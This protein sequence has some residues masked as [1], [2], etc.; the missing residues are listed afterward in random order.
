MRKIIFYGF[1]AQTDLLCGSLTLIWFMT[2]R[3]EPDSDGLH[4]NKF[5]NSHHRI[6]MTEGPSYNVDLI[7]SKYLHHIQLHM[8]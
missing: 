8:I 6:E 5:S 2:E 1:Q 4:T 7:R 3:H